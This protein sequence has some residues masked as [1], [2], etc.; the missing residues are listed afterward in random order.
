[1]TMNQ[2]SFLLICMSFGV[3][4]AEVQ[5]TALNGVAKIQLETVNGLIL[6]VHFTICMLIQ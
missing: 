4:P 3:M 1:M 6:R 5:K 2:M